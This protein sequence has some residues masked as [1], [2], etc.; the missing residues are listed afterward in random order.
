MTA[1]QSSW[2]KDVFPVETTKLSEQQHILVLGILVLKYLQKLIFQKQN[3]DNV[4]TVRADNF[5]SQKAE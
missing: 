4:L 1:L 3:T 2:Q 5:I